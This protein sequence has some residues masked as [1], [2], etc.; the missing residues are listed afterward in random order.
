MSDTEARDRLVDLI[1]WAETDTYATSQPDG[2]A[3]TT[4]LADAILDAGWRPPAR[5]VSTWEEVQSLRE[6]TLV[7]IERWGRMWVYE[8][9]E[10]DACGL[11]G[12]GWL[13][14]DWLPATVIYE[15]KAGE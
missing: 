15:P 12:G 2:M 7:L 4:I 8:C 14:E 13:D 10:D 6:G 3:R 11:R 5:V 9:Q 1:E